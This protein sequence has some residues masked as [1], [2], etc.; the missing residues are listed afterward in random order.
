[1]E[2]KSSSSVPVVSGIPQGTVCCPLLFLL[3]INNLPD[4]VASTTRLFADDSLLYWKVKSEEDQRILLEDLQGLEEWERD[5]Q[6]SFNP[7][8]CEVIRICKRRNQLTC[9]YYIHGHQLHCQV[10]EIPWRH[11]DRHPLLEC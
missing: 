5:L 8:K 7:T 6:M 2:G 9:S 4:R 1:M 11:T 10:W 3:Y